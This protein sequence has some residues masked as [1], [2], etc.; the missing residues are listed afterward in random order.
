MRLN[1]DQ[2]MQALGEVDDVVVAQIIEVRHPA[3]SPR[4]RPGWGT[5]KPC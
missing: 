1:R 5:T 4:L 3:S 2:V